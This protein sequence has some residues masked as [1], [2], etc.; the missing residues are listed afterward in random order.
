MIKTFKIFFLTVALIFAAAMTVS[1]Q[2]PSDSQTAGTSSE[3]VAEVAL[4]ETVAPADLEVSEPTLLPDS[5]FYFLKNLSRAVRSVF[6]FDKV[7]KAELKLKFASEKLLEVKALAEKTENSDVIEKAAKNYEKEIASIKEAAD[8]IKDKASEN[9]TVE[10]FLDKFV[11]QQILHTKILEKLEEQ[12]PEQAMEKIKEARENHLEK[13]GQVMEKLE[14]KTNI[15]ERLEKNINEMEGSEFKSLKD[16]Q[17]LKQ[18]EEKAPEAIKEVVREARQVKLEE[19]KEKL[20]TMPEQIQ[21]RFQEY[22]E[23]IQGAVEQKL[24]IIEDLKL[25]LKAVPQVKQKLEKAKERIM[26]EIK[27][28]TEQQ[29]QETG[30]Q[31]PAVS[32]I[33][34]KG[35]TVLEKDENGCPL[36]RC[37]ILGEEQIRATE[38]IRI[39]EEA[40]IRE[41]KGEG[42]QKE[43][44]TREEETK[45][46]CITLWEPVCGA[47]EKTYSNKCFANLAG[48]EIAYQGE[49][50]EKCIKDGTNVG[51]T[52][53]EAKKIAMNSQCAKKGKLSEK[54]SCNTNSGTWWINLDI[55]DEAWE[56]MDVS[57]EMC[58][59]ACVINV[60]TKETEINWRCTGFLPPL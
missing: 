41:G 37:V 47:D 31:C 23:K 42:E 13:F 24:E 40:K 50:E 15:A 29:S 1:A 36:Q 39:R 26:E 51:L 33:T 32:P 21:E 30:L 48:V 55:F 8:A 2:E 34:C 49:C 16:I 44:Q 6:T 25:E 46:A 12:V 4:D 38:E 59:P 9:P 35:R 14:D 58:S 53:S 27:E 54:A 57:K 52:L 60:V 10:K 19:L 43:E 56:E 20:E 22:A 45:R 5:P 7:K 3:T 11:Q 18:I 28:R 17:I